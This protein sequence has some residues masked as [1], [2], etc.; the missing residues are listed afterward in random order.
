MV[1]RLAVVFSL[2]V[3][4]FAAAAATAGAVPGPALTVDAS[5]PGRPISPEI[6][7]MNGADPAL[8]AELDLPVDRWGGND[9]E[10]Y[11]W[12]IATKNTG[13]DYFFENVADCFQA[14]TGCNV[15][16]PAADGRYRP[17][18]ARQRAMGGTTVMQLPLIGWVARDDG[19]A[20]RREHPFT[21][22]FPQD[23]L[24]PTQASYDFWDPGC[25][26]GRAPDDEADPPAVPVPDHPYVGGD[27]LPAGPPERT[28]VAFGPADAKAWVED[29]VQRYGDAA[30]GGVGVYELGNEPGLWDDSH[31]D[32][33]PD[34]T[35]Y[36]E[37]RD[38]TVAMAT[39]VKQA[40]P[41]AKVIGFSEW[42]WT[43]YFCSALDVAPLGYGCDPDDPDRANHGGME[44]SAWYLKELK[45]ASATAGKRLL[46]DFDLHYYAQAGGYGLDASRGLWDPTY[47]DASWIGTQ[48]EHQ[49]VRLLPRM[50]AWVD[51][52]YPGTGISL[53]EYNLTD[54]SAG[55]KDSVV[56][57]LSEA[58]ALGIFAREGVDLAAM[59]APPAAGDL[60]ADA[61]RLYRS[62][63][64]HGA[65][66]GDAYL[67]SASADQ[68][69]L[70]VYGARRTADGALTVAVLN[71]S[72]DEL[73]AP[74]TVAGF[75][76]GGPAQTWRWTG[77]GI[78]RA[79]DR[80]LDGTAVTF[81]PRSMTM[82]VVPPHGEDP[83]P[84]PGP[85][86]DPDPGPGP[87]PDPGPGPGPGPDPEPG[88]G[89]GPG[90]TPKTPTTT[91]PKPPPAPVPPLARLID[92]KATLKGRAIALRL[93]CPKG[94]ARCGGTLTLRSGRVTLGT[95]KLAL[96]PGRTTAVRVTVSRTRAR[97]IARY[98]RVG[99][100]VKATVAAGKRAKT[101]SLRL[102][103]R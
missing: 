54:L 51:A 45:A 63:D 24:N 3:V 29:L 74:V 16:D 42:G 82:L 97:T 1:Q 7:G 92:A 76:P 84:D 71:K 78:V 72:A 93:S 30:H 2:A 32:V 77:G 36:D 85:G 47:M 58:D 12:R 8:A 38:K 22:G 49:V 28:S 46:D 37:L 87:D 99:R 103:G 101:T 53:S 35:T 55:S 11:N 89:P 70:A 50:R 56:G 66:F 4:A 83:G 41:T 91:S 75:A 48:G 98:G 61:F 94:T 102:R 57:T 100:T 27:E 31:R 64:G 39:A 88:P 96:K 33:H 34:P 95:A 5:G 60:V 18:I 6:Y 40:D 20:A 14:P 68:G 10:R 81:P 86:P 43:N 9:K 26:N 17:L 62:Y 13:R 21:C 25:G 44:L 19:V 79:A 65:R 69:A 59:W 15:L 67:P 52:H 23:P 73:D 90:D 80:V